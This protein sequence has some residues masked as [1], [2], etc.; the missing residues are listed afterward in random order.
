MRRNL[1]SLIGIT[2]LASCNTIGAKQPGKDVAGGE[3]S[4]DTEWQADSQ[5]VIGEIVKVSLRSD[6]TGYASPVGSDLN[7]LLGSAT[8]LPFSTDIKFTKAAEVN[9]TAKFV[10]K[11]LPQASAGFSNGRTIERVVENAEGSVLLPRNT[12]SNK[13]DEIE[14]MPGK[15][16]DLNNLLETIR[17]Q[18]LAGPPPAGGGLYI[19]TKVSKAP[20]IKWTVEY[21]HGLN[22]KVSEDGK[23]A[24]GEIGGSTSGSLSNT[25]VY[26]GVARV[27]SV[28]LHRIGASGAHIRYAE[29]LSGIGALDGE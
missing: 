29:G 22:G 18:Q 23:V 12:V 25:A 10:S 13:L 16:E 17:S 27:Y 8:A 7:P 14:A 3:L 19:V 24:T 21:K 5:P 9:L 28:G 20:S 26:K 15:A 1:A 6:G 4:K 11:L 2:I